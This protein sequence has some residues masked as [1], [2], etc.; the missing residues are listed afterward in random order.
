MAGT[1]RVSFRLIGSR[2]A[3]SKVPAWVR[4]ARWAV[5]LAAI[6][7]LAAACQA[8][9]EG[10]STAPVRVEPAARL[11]AD[12]E[13]R[14]LRVAIAVNSARRAAL[15]STE[16][17]N[18]VVSGLPE[19][20]S[21]LLLVNDADAFEIV[22]AG[23]PQRLDV[24]E[25]PNDNSMTIWPQ[26][27]FLVLEGWDGTRLLTSKTFERAGDRLMATE[28]AKR[29]GY[30]LE[31]SELDFEGGNIVS[32][33]EHILIGANTIR[34][35][36]IELGLAEAEVAGRFQDELG[37]PVLVVGPVP[38]PVAHIDMMLTPLGDGRIALADAE[39]G[40]RIAALALEAEPETVAEFE[41]YCEKYFF[42]HPAIDA[43][44]GKDGQTFAAP[45][46]RG[47]T[48]DM[49]ELSRTIAPVL[50]GI[51]ESLESYGY[52]VERIPFLFGGPEINEPGDPEAV[53]HADY[54]MLTYNNVL[55]ERSGDS[56]VVYLP[57]YGWA[58]MD[59][60]AT[61]AWEHIGFTTR[62]IEGLTISAMYGGALRCAVKVLE[63]TESN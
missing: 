39:E 47:R 38:Q 43:V 56:P 23:W 2:R 57:R 36:A 34:F 54:P 59:D 11:L 20:T 24:V 37:R 42:G 10:R 62:P 9:E 61:A 58:A 35:N 6:G 25:L 60:A 1:R 44:M 5:G 33:D 3:G 8:P 16:F 13:G 52:K 40:A 18:N 26:D 14:P 15:R 50:D 27:P 21:I 45:E 22:A 17:V 53:R 19:D 49:I 55:I 29:T 51:A 12:T 30:R 31:A 4:C 32:D 7:L 28:I 63:R 48:G 41:R 46:V